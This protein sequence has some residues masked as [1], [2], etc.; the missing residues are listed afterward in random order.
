MVALEVDQRSRRADGDET[1]RA[2]RELHARLGVRAH[3]EAGPG[4]RSAEQLEQR[5]GALLV[6]RGIVREREKEFGADA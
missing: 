4:E 3:K 5:I 2:V 1:L 6:L